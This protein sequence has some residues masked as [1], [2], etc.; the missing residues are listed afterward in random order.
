MQIYFRETG[1]GTYT[2]GVWKIGDDWQGC[3]T[4]ENGWQ[5]SFMIPGVLVNIL[6][7][8]SMGYLMS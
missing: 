3:P 5:W 4:I 8:V 6:S 1:I 2:Q 7:K